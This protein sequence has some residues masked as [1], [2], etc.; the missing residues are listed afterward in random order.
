MYHVLTMI[1]DNLINSLVLAKE[2]HCNIGYCALYFKQR[3]TWITFLPQESFID[4]YANL[5][6]KSL[7]LLRWFTQRCEDSQYVMKTDDDVYINL[8][9]LHQLVLANREHGG[10]SKRAKRKKSRKFQFYTIFARL[11]QGQTL[12]LNFPL[13]STGSLIKSKSSISVFLDIHLDSFLQYFI[14]RLKYKTIL[15]GI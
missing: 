3:Q 6:L 12:M 7:L 5:T 14:Q 10:H 15:R 11:C 1:E 9:K 13:F 8:V 4:T 2:T